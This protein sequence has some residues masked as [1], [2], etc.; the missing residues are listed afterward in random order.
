MLI[1]FSSRFEWYDTRFLI[2]HIKLENADYDETGLCAQDLD[3]I[4]GPKSCSVI[5]YPQV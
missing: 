4:L 1:G 5:M 3:T 2:K